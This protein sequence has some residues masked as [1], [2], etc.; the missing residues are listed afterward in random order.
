[1]G[2]TRTTARALA[3]LAGAAGVGP[4]ACAHGFMA[5]LLAP[6]AVAAQPFVRSARVTIDLTAAEGSAS[7]LVEYALEGA[8]AGGSVSIELLGFDEAFTDEVE[9]VG[10]DRIV[11]WPAT[12]S[13]RS[14]TVTLP[15]ELGP[16]PVRM[17][18]AY[19]I[20]AAVRRA[21]ERFHARVPVLTIAA[22]PVAGVGDVFAAD[23]RLPEGWTVADAF[24]SGLAAR[25]PGQLE[26]TLQVVPSVVRVRGRTDGGWRPGL[27]LAL[28]VLA[29]LIVG[30]VIVAGHRHMR[31]MIA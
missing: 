6:V 2:L 15:N 7:V 1:V 26:A 11:L 19:R 25:D 13:R 23:V 28:D 3:L 21:G 31:R 10:G 24:P 29:L 22:P 20:E 16:G 4:S 12:G 17:G 14:A 9:V 30:G 18:F 27:G 5:T 8:R